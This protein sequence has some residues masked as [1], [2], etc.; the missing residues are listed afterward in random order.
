MDT[1][2]QCQIAIVRIWSRSPSEMASF[3]ET[4]EF[5]SERSFTFA[6]SV[7][8]AHPL[9]GGHPYWLPLPE[10]MDF[11]RGKSLQAPISQMVARSR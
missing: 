7:P 3:A 6:P 1:G 2:G 10:H 4:M 5:L 8:L 9:F 11:G